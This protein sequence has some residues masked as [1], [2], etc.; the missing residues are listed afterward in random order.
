MR[1]LISNKVYIGANANCLCRLHIQHKMSSLEEHWWTSWTLQRSVYSSWSSRESVEEGKR[2]LMY[3]EQK[4]LFIYQLSECIQ[5]ST[6]SKYMMG[7]FSNV[8]IARKVKLPL[9]FTDKLNT[10]EAQWLF[11]YIRFT[12]WLF[13][14]FSSSPR[15]LLRSLEIAIMMWCVYK[16]YK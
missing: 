12:I 9:N 4:T 14:D 16:W 5:I 3:T 8:V 7:L 6:F 13:K 10:H 11:Y 15:K 1:L 2:L